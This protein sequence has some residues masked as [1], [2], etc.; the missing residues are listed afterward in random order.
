MKIET[1]PFAVVQL[2]RLSVVQLYQ[3]RECRQHIHMQ[4]ADRR[5]RVFRAAGVPGAAFLAL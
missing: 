3:P 5:R 2:Y 1:V 4:Q